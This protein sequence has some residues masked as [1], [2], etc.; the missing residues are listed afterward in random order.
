MDCLERLGRPADA[1]AG[2]RQLV[3]WGLSLAQPPGTIAA[4]LIGIGRLSAAAADTEA[5]RAAYAKV[6]RLLQRASEPDDVELVREAREWLTR[7]ASTP[8]IKRANDETTG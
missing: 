4:G 8:G 6:A 5:A 2:F 1:L 7:N 3:R